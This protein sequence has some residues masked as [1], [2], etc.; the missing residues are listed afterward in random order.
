MMAVSTSLRAGYSN[1]CLR[2]VF[3]SHRPVAR[4]TP[5]SAAETLSPSWSVIA[6]LPVRCPRASPPEENPPGGPPSSFNPGLTSSVI[7]RKPSPRQGPKAEVRTNRSWAQKARAPKVRHPALVSRL[8]CYHSRVTQ[9]NSATA[10]F[11]KSNPST[12]RASST[13]LPVVGSLIS[14][15]TTRTVAP[16]V[17][18]LNAPKPK[19]KSVLAPK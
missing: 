15:P 2:R 11:V 9:L 19:R 12:W 17:R 5:G 18:S 1:P 8:S 6:R 10:K 14:K 13:G 3:A 7:E 4:P 16:S